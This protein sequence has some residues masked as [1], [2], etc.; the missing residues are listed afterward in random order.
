ME[1]LGLWGDGAPFPSFENFLDCMA[2]KGLGK[3]CWHNV[4]YPVCRLYN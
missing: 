1:R 2:R 4:Y 3:F